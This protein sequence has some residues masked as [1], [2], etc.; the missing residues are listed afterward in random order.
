VEEIGVGPGA[1]V[2]SA[3][4]VE[5]AALALLADPSPRFAGIA[6]DAFGEEGASGG[7]E[8]VVDV[9]FVPCLELPDSLEDG[10]GGVE[11]RG[12]EN[13]GFVG[14]EAAADEIDEAGLMAEAG[15]GAV[16]GEEGVTGLDEGEE[17]VELGWRDA[18]VVGVEEDGVEFGEGVWGEAVGLGL[19][20]EFDGLGFDAFGEEGEVFGGVVVGALVS[21]EE[22]AQGAGFTR[23]GEGGAEG[24]A[25]EG[26]EER[27][28]GRG[29]LAGGSPTKI[30]ESGSG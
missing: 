12:V 25:E 21:Q 29:S 7:V 15:A 22:D 30:P 23:V 20:F 27:A 18:S 16:D 17:G 10:V 3:R 26:E 13:A 6:F 14:F 24:E 1:F 19:V 28:H 2:V 9:G 5:D 11:K 4:G 8:A